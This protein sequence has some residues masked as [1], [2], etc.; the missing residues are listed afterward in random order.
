[1]QIMPNRTRLSGKVLAMTPDPGGAGA[2]VDL[3]VESCQADKG[4]KDFTGAKA[5]IVIVLY[6]GDPAM[7]SEG[8]SYDVTVRVS[9]DAFGQRILVEQ[10]VPLK[11]R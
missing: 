4:Y 7:L 5:G 9:G 6:V 10:A 2:T 1:M 3:L 8:R 11:P